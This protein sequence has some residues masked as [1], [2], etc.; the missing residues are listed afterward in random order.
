MLPVVDDLGHARSRVAALGARF[1]LTFVKNADVEEALTRMGA[2]PGTVQERQPD[3]LPRYAAAVPLGRWTLVVEADGASN[4]DHVLL[5]A[6]SRDTEAV[7]VLRDASAAPRFTYARDG[8]TAVA[9]DPSYP[10]P[11]LTWGAEPELLRHLMQALALREPAGE[12]DETWHDPEA[13]ALV[14]AQ[15]LTGARVPADA[16]EIPRLSGRLEPWFVGGPRPADLLK[17]GNRTAAV[18]AA[19]EEASPER[20]RAV[21]AD[22]VRRLAAELGVTGAPGLAGHL[23][24]PGPVTPESEL[25]RQVIEW[26][27]DPARYAALT[28]ALRG[29]GDPDSLVALRAA[30]KPGYDEQS[31]ITALADRP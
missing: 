20:R 26:L 29:I 28:T 13:K 10:S 2:L 3:E 18:L 4:G 24:H 1:C 6:V 30:L 27:A 16:L 14:L 17:R 31:V 8:V 12:D 21:A 7:S 22:H 23:A 9:F 25:G 11:E 5:E 15:R 19:A